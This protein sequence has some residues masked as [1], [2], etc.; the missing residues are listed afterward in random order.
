MFVMNLSTV[1]VHEMHSVLTVTSSID[2]SV[3]YFCL[4]SSVISVMMDHEFYRCSSKA[5]PETQNKQEKISRS[6]WHENVRLLHELEVPVGG[7]L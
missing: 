3:F 1:F 6:V 2:F 4:V 5:M 7:S